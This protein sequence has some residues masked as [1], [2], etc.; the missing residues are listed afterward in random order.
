[1]EAVLAAW[2]EENLTYDH[3][4]AW[5]NED[6]ATALAVALAE[7]GIGSLAQARAEGAQAVVDAVEAHLSDGINAAFR[8]ARI[9]AAG[10][11]VQFVAGDQQEWPDSPRSVGSDDESIRERWGLRP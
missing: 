7:A 3:F 9:A 10:Q 1:V 6:F 11:G 2:F 8:M 5:S 4:A